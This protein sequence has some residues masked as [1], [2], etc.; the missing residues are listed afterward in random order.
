MPT[1]R[2]DLVTAGVPAKTAIEKCTAIGRL[3]V[4]TGL[5]AAD[6]LEMVPVPKGARITDISIH[7]SASLGG[8]L[9]AS[10]GDGAAAARFAAAAAFGQGAAGL[11]RLSAGLGHQYTAND[12]VDIVVATAATPT[13]GTVV[14]CVVEYIMGDVSAF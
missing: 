3:T 10:I 1:Y 11:N 5:A 2:S 13:T 6:I 14:T 8:T 12:T 4:G 9:T 7:A